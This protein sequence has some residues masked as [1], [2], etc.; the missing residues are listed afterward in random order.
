MWLCS[1]GWRFTY[2]AFLPTLMQPYDDK[3]P[4]QVCE[5]C[6]WG[7]HEGVGGGNDEKDQSAYC[8]LHAVLSAME[9][10]GL[11]LTL[12]E[13]LIPSYNIN[14]P[15]PR[16]NLLAGAEYFMFTFLNLLSGSGI[17]QI[18]SVKNLHESAIHRYKQVLT[19]RPPALKILND[20]IMNF[21]LA[22]MCVKDQKLW[23]HLQE[24]VR[25]R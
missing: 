13:R 4:E 7:D 21:G 2:I 25:Y 22:N 8:A 9:K 5:F 10:R 1:T 6:C 14:A 12:D 23:R 16:M 24:T 17:R 19:W 20:D 18:K 11:Q 3:H 15:S